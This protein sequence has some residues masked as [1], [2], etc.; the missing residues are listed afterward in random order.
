[1][2][3]IEIDLNAPF[4][5]SM[6]A[7]LSLPSGG[8]AR[9]CQE[10]VVDALRRLYTVAHGRAVQTS[11]GP[12]PIAPPIDPSLKEAPLSF[13]CRS[14]LLAFVDRRNKSVRAASERVEDRHRAQEFP[15]HITPHNVR[16]GGGLRKF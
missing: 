7:A 3:H 8:R 5:Q 11:L 13:K 9:A 2:K 16:I 14:E 1:M 4:E 10:E 6:R 15:V 12:I